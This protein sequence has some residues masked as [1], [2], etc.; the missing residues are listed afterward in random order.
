MKQEILHRLV[1][2]E[3]NLTELTLELLGRLPP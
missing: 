3:G 2:L 1:G